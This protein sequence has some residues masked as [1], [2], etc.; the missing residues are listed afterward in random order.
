MVGADIVSRL[1]LSRGSTVL[2]LIPT[3]ARRSR[4]KAVAAAT[5]VKAGFAASSWQRHRRLG[6]RPQSC[7][8]SFVVKNKGDRTLARLLIMQADR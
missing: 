1:T 8:L 4:R 3:L 5:T 6:L 7:R 2:S